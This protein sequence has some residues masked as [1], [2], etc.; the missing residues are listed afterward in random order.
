VRAAT[1]REIE[2]GHAAEPDDLHV[3]VANASS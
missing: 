1:P 2:D 3:R